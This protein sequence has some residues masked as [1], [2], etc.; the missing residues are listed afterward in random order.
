MALTVCTHPQ[1][2]IEMEAAHS[3]MAAQLADALAEIELRRRREVIADSMIGALQDEVERL[4]GDV[5]MYMR[6]F[7]QA[8]KGKA[9][10]V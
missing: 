2:C 7:E 1:R 8:S 10:T 9:V 4:Q 5:T 3:D 6:M